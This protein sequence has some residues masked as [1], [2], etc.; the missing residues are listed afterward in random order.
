MATSGYAVIDTETTGF[1]ARDRVIEIGVVLLDLDLT[2]VD[3]WDTLLNPG[4]GVGPTHVH[5]ISAADVA[6]AP[7]FDQAAGAVIERL[8]GRVVVGH[9]VSFDRRMLNQEFRRLGHGEPVGGDFS[10]DTLGLARQLG[11]SPTSCYTLDFLCSVYRID[12]AGAHAALHDA[13]ATASLFALVARRWAGGPLGQPCGWP[14]HHAAAGRAVWPTVADRGF[15][16]L[17]RTRV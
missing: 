15:R 13:R 14:G 6:S 8:A 10:L 11:L 1:G 2:P 5:R 4:R 12:R 16:P 7:T 3:A 17:S 9:N